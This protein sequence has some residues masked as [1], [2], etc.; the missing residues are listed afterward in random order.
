MMHISVPFS[1]GRSFVGF[2]IRYY[3]SKLF[4]PIGE[5]LKN[6][7]E[8]FPEFNSIGIISKKLGLCK[9]LHYN[10]LVPANRSS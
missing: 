3:V 7:L 4:L 8:M 2:A 9:K 10:S 1:A 6:S 5:T